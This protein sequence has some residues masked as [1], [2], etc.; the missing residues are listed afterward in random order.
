MKN[1]KKNFLYL[2]QLIQ[3]HDYLYHE[4]DTPVISDEEYDFLLKKYNIIK[5]KHPV[6]CDEFYNKPL[7]KRNTFNNF[8]LH[9]HFIPML[10]LKNTFDVNGY[11]NF[12]KSIQYKFSNLK[13][14][15]FF[16]EL[17][18][19]GLALSLLYQKGK[20]I[21]ALT[22]GDGV[23]GEDVT[24]NVYMIKNIPIVLHGL[25][26]PDLLEIR[27]EVCMLKKDFECLNSSLLE[28]HQQTFSNTRNAASGSLRNHNILISKK[29]KLFF[30]GYGCHVISDFQFFSSHSVQINFL[31]SLGFQTSQYVLLSTKLNKILRFYYLMNHV[32]DF[33]SFNFDGVVIKVDDLFLQK[34]LGL[35]NKFPRWS[36]AFKFFSKHIKTKLLSIEY[37]VGRTGIITPVAHLKPVLL[38]GVIVKKASLYNINEIKKLDIFLNDSV[39]I[40]RVG[41]VIPKIHSV[42]VEDR[43]YDSNRVIF[44]KYCP[45]C[46][47]LLNINNNTSIVQCLAGI[48]CKDQ[49]IRIIQHFFSK[50]GLYAKG[51]NI[52]VIKKLIDYKCI[53]DILD[54]LKLDF[55]Q[56]SKLKFFGKTSAN[57]IIS[58]IQKSKL[59]TLYRFLYALGIPEV[60][61]EASLL[62]SKYFGCLENLFFTSLKDFIKIKNIGLSIAKSVFYFFQNMKNINHIKVLINQGNIKFFSDTKVKKKYLKSYFMGKKVAVT[63]KFKNFSRTEIIKKINN[64][65]GFFKKNVSSSVDFIIIGSKPGKKVV[66]ASKLKIKII[67]ES[68][69]YKLYFKKLS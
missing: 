23:F 34:K 21:R 30:Y 28:N 13:H 37:H 61:I 25:N 5:N 7:F 29:R 64:S 8:K 17:K 27:G 32:R 1:I 60:G 24:M 4:L 40:S 42:I 39:M 47:S 6:L 14:V 41:D 58:S 20:L 31:S 2:E 63:G 16:C 45:S 33:L 9:R 36:I 69:F 48:N 38:S 35:T 44:P 56:L 51:F 65:G 53:R 3:Y 18:F 10:S 15:R 26:I 68:D 50:N 19:D 12:H 43:L 49:K 66:Q 59:T 54:C 67:S 46:R 57:N 55:L 11:I 52:G 62:L 22:R